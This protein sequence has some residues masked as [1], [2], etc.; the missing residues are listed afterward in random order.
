MLY[1][2][3]N[4][5]PRSVF[6]SAYFNGRSDNTDVM[7]LNLNLNSMQ[8]SIKTLLASTTITAV[9]VGS[10]IKFGMPAIW[11]GLLLGVI[12]LGTIAHRNKTPAPFW[13]CIGSAILLWHPLLPYRRIIP[14]SGEVGFSI[15]AFI[16]GA[17]L[18]GASIQRG[19]W[20]TR[21]MAV[22][23]VVLYSLIFATIVLA[24]ILR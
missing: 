7:S 24:V 11:T 4:I 20:T 6:W 12:A 13:G 2:G 23:M 1:S 3:F 14:F 8:F 22:L 5:L 17:C 21:A 18:A 10:Y 19:H 16:V 9:A 15:L